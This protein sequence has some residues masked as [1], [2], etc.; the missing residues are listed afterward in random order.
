VHNLK[1]ITPE[2]NFKTIIFEHD[3]FTELDI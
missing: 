1:H 3:I 2:P